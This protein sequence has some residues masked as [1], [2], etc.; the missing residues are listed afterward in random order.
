MHSNARTKLP[1]QEG[2]KSC[3]SFLCL[4]LYMAQRDQQLFAHPVLFLQAGWPPCLLGGLMLS[5]QIILHLC[6]LQQ[7]FNQVDIFSLFILTLTRSETFFQGF[8]LITEK[9]CMLVLDTQTMKGAFFSF[10]NM[11]FLTA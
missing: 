6:R 11:S 7:H 5:G 3:F 1:L 9:I 8:P 10:S 2:W 4:N